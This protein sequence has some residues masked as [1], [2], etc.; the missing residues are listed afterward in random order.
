VLKPLSPALAVCAVAAMVAVTEARAQTAR[1][2]GPPP[3][4]P[5]HQV[6][7][8]GL[9]YQIPG[10][11]KAAV[12]KD[13]VYKTVE[14]ASLALDLYMPGD[15]RPGESVPVIVFM[16]TIGDRPGDPMKEWGQYRSW[17]RLAAARGYAGISFASRPDSAVDDAADLLAWVVS[18]AGELGL[19]ASR[20]GLWACSAH[21]MHGLPALMA[22]RFP[23]AKAAVLYYGAADVAAFDKDLP[24]LLVRAGRDRAF[25]N[26]KV[27]QVIAAAASANAPWSVINAPGLHHG[28]DCLDDLDD[29]RRVIRDTMDW[30]DR[31]LRPEPLPPGAPTLAREALSYWFAQEWPLAADAYARYVK[32]HPDDLV[33]L[34]RLGTSQIYA[35]RFDEAIATFEHVRQK[36]GAPASVS[37][38]IACAYALKGEKDQALTALERAVTEGMNDPRG[39]QEDPDLASLRDDARF[40]ALKD[41][42]ASK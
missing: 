23:Q 30:F 36:G 19:D 17:P 18:H 4:P 5:E 3:G 24:V 40:L 14:G 34:N 16:N 25:V 2:A 20:I 6:T 10:M 28:F 27:D 8:Y 21:V 12:R 31:H 13:I 37:Y 9:V 39:L 29:S 15:R 11:E 26:G 38:N 42:L 7:S 33:A 32:S 1:P 22:G 35:R 41:R